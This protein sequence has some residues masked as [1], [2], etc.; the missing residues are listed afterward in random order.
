MFWR[1]QVPIA[2]I[3]SLVMQ[4]YNQSLEEACLAVRALSYASFLQIQTPHGFILE[5][6]CLVSA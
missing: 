1:M 5:G 6:D 4:L 3:L 2:A